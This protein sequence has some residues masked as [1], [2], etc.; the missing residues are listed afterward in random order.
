[1]APS[2]YRLAGIYGKSF[3]WGSP[4]SG[5]VFLKKEITC[6]HS[7]L[8]ELINRLTSR[9]MFGCLYSHMDWIG[10][11]KDKMLAQ[12]KTAL[13]QSAGAGLAL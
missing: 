12:A 11:T 8:D 2:I 13:L 9:M 3:R 10:K 5:E 4:P 1:L 6:N 7:P